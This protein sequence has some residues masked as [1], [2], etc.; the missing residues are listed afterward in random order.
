MVLEPIRPY[1]KT[2][3]SS[4]SRTGRHFPSTAGTHYGQSRQRV[5]DLAQ[6]YQQGL[7]PSPDE[8]ST[9]YPKLHWFFDQRYSLSFLPSAT[10]LR[11]LRSQSARTEKPVASLEPFI[12]FGDP[13]LT[14]SGDER[15]GEMPELR[16]AAIAA[17]VRALPALPGTRDELLVEAQ[18]FGA[19]PGNS[20]YLGD[21]ATRSNL[22][23]LNSGR[24]DHISTISFATHALVGGEVNGLREPA[25]VLTPPAHPSDQ[26]VGLLTLGDILDL[27]LRQSDW[28]ILSACN[29]GGTDGDGLSGSARA[30]FYAGRKSLLVSQWSIDD[31]AT[32]E[33][34]KES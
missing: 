1:L 4:S 11:F 9:L 12:G 26:D 7:N 27:K 30:F 21:R 8:L 29:T 25:L 13:T 10:S 5:C 33:L 23:S 34:M 28:I 32:L 24:L 22:M 31:H 3:R 19:D 2:R 16:G 18:L 6:D 14:G 15:G 20:V 17:Q